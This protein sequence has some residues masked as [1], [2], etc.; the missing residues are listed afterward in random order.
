MGQPKRCLSEDRLIV[1]VVFGILPHYRIPVS[2]LMDLSSDI[3]YTFFSSNEDDFG[4]KHGD[5]SRLRSFVQARYY[6]LGNFIFQPAGIQLAFSKRFDAIVYL[7]DP[8]YLSTWIGVPIARLLGRRVLFWTHGWRRSKARPLGRQF[9]NIFYRMANSLLVYSER[10]R[11]LGIGFGYPA[12]RIDVV[13]NSLDADRAAAV[14]AAIEAEPARDRPQALFTE[15]DRPLLIC[16]ARLTEACR[17]DLLVDAAA[18]LAEAG[19]PVNV[20]LVGDGPE[21]ERLRTRAKAQGVETHF[22]GACYDEEVLGRMLYHAD[23]TV[24]PGKVGLTALHSL[25]YGTPVITHDNLDEQMPEVEV[26]TEGRTGA[27]FRQDDVQD[28]TD[29]IASWLAAGH[30]RAAIRQSCR[31]VIRMKWNPATQ[32]EIIRQALLR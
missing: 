19:A 22:F 30:D 4:I 15:Q 23:L 9:R 7:G 16:T 10:G 28:L 25:T 29:T 24:S 13:Y 31:D 18:R 27:L 8:H 12:D 20:L 14:F 26:V 21:R 32:A 6:R 3:E 11:R 5:T 17:F 1:A 2:E